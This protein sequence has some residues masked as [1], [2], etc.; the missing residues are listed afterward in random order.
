[1]AR[2][3]LADLGIGP[4]GAVGGGGGG[5]APAPQRPPEATPTQPPETP[6]TARRASGFVA[7][8]RPSSTAK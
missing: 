3:D 1:M 8:V 7:G 4:D 2:Q 5:T 6:N